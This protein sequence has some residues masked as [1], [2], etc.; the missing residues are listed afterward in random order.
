MKVRYSPPSDGTQ[1]ETG[2]FREDKGIVTW[3]EFLKGGADSP[4]LTWEQFLRDHE[5]R[6]RPDSS[7]G[8]KCEGGNPHAQRRRIGGDP[9]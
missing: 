5:D 8:N 7:A 6:V 4:T 9:R 3:E 1:S 2:S